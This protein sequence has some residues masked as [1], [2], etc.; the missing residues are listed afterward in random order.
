MAQLIQQLQQAVQELQGQVQD[1]QGDREAK[2]IDTQIK[3]EGEDRRAKAQMETQILMKHMDLLNPVAGE[4][5]AE[6]SNE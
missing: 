1:K 4:K 5:K 2:L 6:A 3:Q